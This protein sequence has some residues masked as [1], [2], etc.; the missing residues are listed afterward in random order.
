MLLPIVVL[1]VSFVA[2]THM[3][4]APAAV[5]AGA[6]AIGAVSVRA[7]HPGAGGQATRQQGRRALLWTGVVLVLAWWMPLVDEFRPSG[8]HNFQELARYFAQAT[9]FDPRR[10][11]RAFE[12][13]IVAPFTPGLALDW[14]H[15]PLARSE[16]VVRALVFVQLVGLVGTSFLAWRR[17]AGSK[18]VWRWCVWRAVLRG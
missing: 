15:T 17:R 8:W 16:P 13:L 11:A 18:P 1:L 2:Q 4:Y 7:Y 5:V 14:G 12:H 9:P 3:G 6:L 10:A